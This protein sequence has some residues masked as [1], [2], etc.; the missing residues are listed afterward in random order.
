MVEVQQ[1]D[2]DGG[3]GPVDKVPD[4]VFPEMPQVQDNGTRC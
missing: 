3:D 4:E 2:E 1:E